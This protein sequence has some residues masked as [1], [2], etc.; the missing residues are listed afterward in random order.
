MANLIIRPVTPDDK[1]AWRR[2]YQGYA[3]F[4]KSEQTDEMAETVWTWLFDETHVEEGLVADLD[5]E[6][7]GLAHFRPQPRPLRG[8]YVGFLD[9][10]FVDPDKRGSGAA[11]ALMVRLNEIA[12]D[13]NWSL[14]RWLTADDNYRARGL[15]D[16]V[17]RKT[18]WNLYEMD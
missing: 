1:P 2:L 10:L 15:Y 8:G 3:D 14:F 16:R 9:D 11:E 6:V 17:G 12:K 4:Y 5:G 13:R 18:T 7:I